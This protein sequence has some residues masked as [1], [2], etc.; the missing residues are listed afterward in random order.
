M[1]FFAEQDRSRSKAFQLII[2]FIFAVALV[3]GAVY[4]A[5]MGVYYYSLMDEPGFYAPAFE[6]FNPRLF[7]IASGSTLA[8][9]LIGSITKIIALSKGGSYV[10][11]S[12]GGRLVNRST[13]DKDERKLFNVV[14][15]MSIASGVPMPQ[16]YI[17]DDENGINAFAAGYSTSDAAVAVTRGCCEILDR[18][19]LQGVIAHEFSH[20]LNGDMRLN[21]RLIGVLS[22]IMIIANIGRIIIYSGSGRRHRH[23]HHHHHMHRT[24]TRTSGRGGAQ[25]LIAGLLL[26]VIGYLGVLLGRMIQSA[27][28]RQREYLADASS[29]QFTRNPSGIANA[30]K[31]IG[32]FS[33]GSKI[34]SPFAE[35][36][37]HMF[38][39]NAINSLF[40]THPPI[41]DRIRKVEPNFDGKFIKSSIP[42]QKAEAVSSFSGGQKETPLKGSVSQMNLDADTIVK[43]AGKVTPE[44]VAYSSQ[45]ISAIPEKVR[46]SIDDAFGATM[47]ICALLLDKDIEEK[48]TQ[49]KHLSRVAPEKIIKQILITEKSLKNIDTRLRLPLIDLSMPALRMMPPSLYAKLNAYIDIL[50]EADGKLTLFEFSL[51]EIIKHR[52]GVV[53]KKNKRKIKF[54]SIKQLSEETENL[55]SKLAHVGHSD[56]TTANEAF[57]A[58]IKKVPIVGKT[59]KIIPNNKVKF[60]AIGTALDHFASATP[61]VKKIVFNACAHCALYDKKV[62]IKEAELLRAIAY[63][64]DIPIPPFLS[65][66]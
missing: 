1:D 24:T 66:S 50:V 49:I 29:V 3:V 22:G 36:A 9:I 53:F 18:D 23:H 44:N 20:I 56:K 34:A 4:A 10:A 41:Q 60:T 54:N 17:M 2:M 47:V 45:L 25:I 55:L 7:L 40:A 31:K 8:V 21:I 43:Q 39:G 28:S 33:L 58:A 37:S 64:I 52:L 48:K 13:R 35:E 32:G 30:L 38:F 27:L 6:W 57:D 5:F 15:E 42:D 12:L 14:E 62:S 16:V 61:G 51:K 46:G 65:K 19:E 63:S 26:I 11:E 59:M